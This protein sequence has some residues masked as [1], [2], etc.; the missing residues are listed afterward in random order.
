LAAIGM[1]S[2]SSVSRA[3][4]LCECRVPSA[5]AVLCVDQAEELLVHEGRDDAQVLIAAL[6]RSGL[7]LPVGAQPTPDIYS[8]NYLGSH[9]SPGQIRSVSEKR[10]GM[11]QKDVRLPPLE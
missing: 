2:L 5:D 8:Y 11:F 6:A 3:I 1:R 10:T 4:L 7:S 9:K